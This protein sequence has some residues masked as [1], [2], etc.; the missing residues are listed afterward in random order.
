[1]PNDSNG[2]VDSTPVTESDWILDPSENPDF[3]ELAANISEG[4]PSDQGLAYDVQ[5][6]I[7]YYLVDHFSEAPLQN[8][9]IAQSDLEEALGSDYAELIATDLA[10][11]ANNQLQFDPAE[12]TATTTEAAEPVNLATGQFTYSATDFTVA[13]A[14][15]DFAFVRTYK[16]GAFS[17]GPLGFAWDHSAN[18][19]IYVNNDATLT[20]SPS[21]P[22]LTLHT[23]QLRP[24]YYIYNV[25]VN[26]PYYVAIGDESII[27][28]TIDGS[29]E[30]QSPDGLISRFENLSNDGT[31]YQITQTV[32]RFGNTIWFN[33][34]QINGQYLLTTITVNNT[35]RT[36]TFIYNEQAQI[37]SIML[38]P[39]TYFIGSGSS[40]VSRTW[41]FEYDECGDLIAVTSPSTDE[42]P[43]GCTTQYCYSS[44][45]SFANR[46]HD[47]LTITDPNGCTFL[48][49][50]YGH[51]V[52]TVAFGRVV[53]QRVGAGEFQFQWE[54][55]LQ[56]PSW[57]FSE[58]DCP[59]SQV[60]LIQRNG[61]PVCYVLNA[62]GNMLLSRESVLTDYGF[63]SIVW[64]YAYDADGRQIA[65]LS[66]EGRITQTYYG[67]EYYYD[68]N[69]SGF[70]SENLPLPWEDSELSAQEHACFSN[71]LA[72]VQRGSLFDFTDDLSIYGDIFPE[73][74]TPN[75]RGGTD[76]CTKYTYEPQFQQPATSS[77]PRY[78]ASA[79]PGNSLESAA[80]FAHL[81]V[82][83]FNGV[84]PR[85]LPEAITFPT[86]T[87][88]DGTTG[89]LSAQLT[90]NS[91]DAN[92][93]L[94]E[95][96]DPEGNIVALTYFPSSAGTAEGFLASRTAAVGT[97]NLVTSFT[98]NEAGQLIAVTDPLGHSVEYSLDARSLV[99]VVTQPLPGYS[100]VSSYDGNGQVT[101]YFNTVI[102]PDGTTAV[103]SPEVSNFVYNTEMSPVLTSYGDSSGTPLR[104]LRRVYDES[105]C[106]IRTILP[107]GNSICYEYD[108]RLLLK[109]TTRGCCS[110]D[111]A[112]TAYAYDLDGRLVATTDPRGNVTIQNLDALGRPI[113]ITDPIGTLQRID[114]DQLN[115]AI[116]RRWIGAEA[117]GVYP[118]LRR[119]E[120]LYDERNQ[121]VRVRHAVFITPI[122]VADP[123]NAPDAEYNAALTLGEVE[124]NDT[125][126]YCDGNLRPFRI[127][128]ANGNAVTIDY[129]AANRPT[130]FTDAV[131]SIVAATYDA[132]GNVTRVDRSCADATGAIRA[133]IS[134][135][136]EYDPL[137]R[138]I[139]T[140]DGVGNTV[141]RALDS[142]D[143]LLTQTDA[144]GHET[145]WTY[146]PFRER[147]SETQVLLPSGRGF[148]T[149][150]TTTFDYDQNGNVVNLTD[151]RGNSTSTAYDLLDRPTLVVNPDQTSRSVIYDPCSNAVRLTDEDGVVIS[152]TFDAD[153]RITSVALQPSGRTPS[154]AEVGASFT[155][156]GMGVLIAHTNAFVSVLRNCDSLGRCYRE[157]FTFAAP[158]DGVPSPLT[159]SRGFDA[160]SNVIRLAYPSGQVLQLGYDPANHLIQIESVMNASPYPGDP[161][162]LASRTIIQKQWWGNLPFAITTVNGIV[163]SSAYDAAARR[164][165]DSSSLPNGDAFVLQQLWD[166]AG[167]RRL[168]LENYGNTIT[169]SRYD[170]DS[171]NRLSDS[172][173][174]QRPRIFLASALAPP[175]VPP[176]TFNPTGQTSIDSLFSGYSVNPSGQL[177]LSYDAAGNRTTE[178]SGGSGTNYLSNKRNEYT[179][180][181][182]ILMTY[183]KTG[184]IL[185]DSNFSYAYNF[186]GQLVQASS[187]SGAGGIQVFH[188]ALGRTVGLVDG[189]QTRVLVPDGLHAIEFYD[190]GLLSAVNIV[191]G[192]DQLCFF[193]A[194]GQDQY[195]LRDVLESTRLAIDAS[196]AATGVFYY[197]PFGS[198]L[199]GTP[200]T[201]LRY[202]GKYQYLPIDWYDY[203]RRQYI[204]GLGR[205]AQPDPAGFA[206]GA[207]LYT[208]VRNNP[209]SARDPNGT[210]QEDIPPRAVVRQSIEP[211]NWDADAWP[212]DDV[213]VSPT[214]PSGS[215]GQTPVP[216]QV[217]GYLAPQAPTGRP[218]VPQNTPLSLAPPAQ[219]SLPQSSQILS[220]PPKR[221][222]GRPL[223]SPKVPRRETFSVEGTVMGQVY[224]R[225]KTL[226]EAS[227]MAKYFR[228]VG[229]LEAEQFYNNKIGKS[230]AALMSDYYKQSMKGYGIFFLLTAIATGPG[231]IFDAAFEGVTG[232]GAVLENTTLKAAAGA[233]GDQLKDLII[234]GKSDW[235]DS[236]LGFR[237]GLKE[238]GFKAFLKKAAEGL[239][240]DSGLIDGLMQ[241]YDSSHSSS[242]T[243]RSLTSE[244]T[245]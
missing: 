5:R 28:P 221:S 47:L 100:L 43:Q 24:I 66:P 95:Y 117:N 48:E 170:Y 82:V 99:R 33:Y 202:S 148:P 180:V 104:Q 6:A 160:V 46:Q 14:G 206:D 81:T 69:Y 165:E 83:T 58:A 204:P 185:T 136:S 179:T 8:L 163:F 40:L 16:S 62:M 37:I 97:L 157:S 115:N 72:T 113:G 109:R 244:E 175:T 23:G 121:L 126:T 195:V 243:I 20:G 230:L 245:R 233:I 91:Y 199:S 96:T 19:W 71:V 124:L 219:S 84:D 7:G 116:V 39:T 18:L 236:V 235:R 10:A 207:N 141:T 140:T 35:A 123:W 212:P 182:T 114:Y 174:L 38:F 225:G 208:F 127:V 120:F 32:D 42:F 151:P 164:I 242:E 188:D 145:E 98:L 2:S 154:S 190:D 12:I 223:R 147:T 29:F 135:A 56:N 119:A 89:V 153:N 232:I 234:R 146:S 45:S 86:T 4:D 198:L 177:Q 30:R 51:A 128:D 186:R 3:S 183:T 34:D 80:Y 218:L 172:F 217:T 122:A 87:Y 224:S 181:G 49:N 13:G 41:S 108:E 213:H 176:A 144:L 101:S 152:Q 166:G 112:V 57:T 26:P 139:S 231:A 197:D 194:G 150:L 118:L 226:R 50:T 78:T 228:S 137:N 138:L 167:N 79:D 168:I 237:K 131:G 191:E 184:R 196:G 105:N 162:A 93:R 67:R 149:P 169:G 215:P 158:L 222:H 94:T 77:D 1:M 155:F 73:A 52:G 11:Y 75:A 220:H 241:V 201:P 193:A 130:T 214:V 25:A 61:H 27:V 189:S 129:D 125:L 227:E 178:Q 133:V 64:R 74:T 205:F 132:S 192:R 90:F 17:N 187:A 59:A 70:S 54:N 36:V 216:D 200:G 15:I 209:L 21:L 60:T 203:R 210:N 211:D 173:A 240:L 65:T 102:Q 44:S 161:S 142:R 107:R 134:T 111:A 22:G 156:D 143:L 68:Q 103:G 53:T 239:G 238:E 106:L 229:D 92:G 31:V 9:D 76:I 171:T 110:S 88:P 55:V 159:I 63:Q 85:V